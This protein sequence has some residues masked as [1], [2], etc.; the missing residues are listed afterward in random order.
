[1]KKKVSIWGGKLDTA[2]YMSPLKIFEYMAA[3]K[4][5][6][7]SDLPV[8][9]EVLSENNA[10]LCDPNN[11]EQWVKAITILKNDPL[12][13]RRLGNNA[14]KTLQSN[15]TWAIRAEKVLSI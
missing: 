1:M 11:I 7:C 12:S 8:I 9:R 15:Y 13:R 3:G 4:P 5:I 2:S 14:R 6:I 10:M